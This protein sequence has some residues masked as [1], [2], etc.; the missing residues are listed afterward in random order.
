MNGMRKGFHFLVA[1]AIAAFALLSGA[2]WAAKTYTLAIS[3]TSGP[4]PIAMTA[5]FTA[6]GSS[7]FN[8][9]TLNLPNNY[10]FLGTPNISASQGTVSYANGVI[11]VLNISAPIGSGNNEVITVTMTSLVSTGG[12]CTSGLPSNWTATVYEGSSLNGQKFQG[13]S[14]TTSIGPLC[15]TATSS[16]DGSGDGSGTITPASQQVPANTSATFTV[17][18]AAGSSVAVTSTCGGS[19]SG[20]TYTTGAVG[21]GGCSVTAKFT[22]ISYPVTTATSGNGSGTVSPTSAS[23]KFGQTTSFTLTPAASS[24]LGGASDNCGAGG[25]LS[26]NTWT[27]GPV[28]VG[29]C[30]VTANF[31]LKTFTVSTSSSGSGSI[32]PPS[33]LVN[34]NATQAFT[35]TPN[36]GSYISSTGGCGGSLSGNTYTTGPVTAACV[37]SASFMPQTLTITSQPTSAAVGTPFNVTLGVNPGPTT[38]TFG[39]G[40][41]A[42]ASL[43]SSTTTSQ[44]WSVTVNSLPS[45]ATCTITFS[46]PNYQSAMVSNLP[47]YKGVL[48]CGDYDSI[49]GPTDLFYDPYADVSYVGNPGWG[50]RRG[51]NKDGSTCVKVNYTCNFDAG[52]NVGGCTYDKASGQKATFE[53]LFLWTPKAPDANGWT[54]YRPQVSWNVPNPDS[55]YALPD[56]VPL[57]ACVNDMFPALP[58]LPTT[59]LPVIPSVLPFTDPLNTLSQYQPN[60]QQALV[61]GAQQGWT[62][63]GTPPNALL[64]VWDKVIDESDFQMKGP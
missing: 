25:S 21:S 45:P 62:A 51:P 42:T 38:V 63:V 4:S 39:A 29:G 32:S 22:L 46:A 58:T 16:V 57:L 28:P 19:L 36:A 52:N 61:C 7:T 40:C 3:P 44:T 60:G 6:S 50:L 30:T 49:N 59:I 10:S 2:A 64:Q 24:N 55:T 47:V 11:S 56:W 31:T 9:F 33:A 54:G 43:T 12:T 48:F 26:G 20:S 8:S 18:P 15:Y 53:Y 1:M 17:S 23:V 13:N 14:V 35:I 27:T 37:V 41:D 5:T 34:Y